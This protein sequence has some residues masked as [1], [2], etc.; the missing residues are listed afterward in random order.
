MRRLFAFL[1][2][3]LGRS[4]VYHR[5]EVYMRRW[6]AGPR[7]WFGIRLH[8]ILRSDADPELHDH[9]FSFAT[10]VLC[11]GYWEYTVDG[12]RT[13]YGPGSLLIRSAEVL[14]RLELERPAWTLV[15]RGPMRREWGFLTTIGWMPWR[16]FVDAKRGASRYADVGAV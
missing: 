9:P 15:L 11:G 5:G 14:H 12:R 13:R 3:L 1:N 4:D 2:R 6:R 8:H 7:R 10:L 16:R